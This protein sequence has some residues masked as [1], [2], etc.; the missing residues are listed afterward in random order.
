MKVMIDTGA[1]HS[2]INEKFIR[3]NGQFKHFKVH[4]EKFLLVDGLTS[5]LNI[6][7]GDKITNIPAFIAKNDLNPNQTSSIIEERTTYSILL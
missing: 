2:F 1:N 3:F 7:I 5:Q 4:H 6:L